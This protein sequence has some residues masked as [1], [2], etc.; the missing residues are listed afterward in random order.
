MNTFNYFLTI[1]AAAGII[2]G[3]TSLNSY[4]QSV[5]NQVFIKQLSFENRAEIY[6][7]AQLSDDFAK[8]NL[9]DIFQDG[10]QHE[11]IIKQAFAGRSTSIQNTAIAEQGGEGHFIKIDQGVNLGFSRNNMA[12]VKQR[13]EF[14]TAVIEQAKDEGSATD[15]MA[16]IRQLDDTHV[17]VIKQGV[18]GG[19]AKNNLATIDQDGTTH[20][21]SIVQ[22]SNFGEAEDNSA[23]IIQLG[24]LGSEA[25]VF[26]GASVGGIG[27]GDAFNNYAYVKQDGSGH[28]ALSIQNNSMNDV[29]DITQQGTGHFARVAQGVV[30]P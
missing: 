25:I 28:Y 16:S 6:Q 1:S 8:E 27:E 29:V 12:E 3:G 4:A 23:E 10:S 22:G 30:L 13:N 26:Q 11:A 9:A 20:S 14:H 5:D 7:G 2:L 21:A 18:E 24:G 17:A 19:D 15:N